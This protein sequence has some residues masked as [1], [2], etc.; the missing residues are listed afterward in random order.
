M[1]AQIIESPLEYSI[2]TDFSEM[3][4]TIWQREADL[5]TLQIELRKNKHW[6]CEAERKRDNLLKVGFQNYISNRYEYST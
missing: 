4:L 2:A 3:K 1:K 6:K 5:A